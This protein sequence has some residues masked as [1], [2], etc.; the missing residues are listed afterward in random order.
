MIENRRFINREE[1]VFL[2]LFLTTLIYA[3]PSIFWH[4]LNIKY[5]LYYTYIFFIGLFS[6]YIFIPIYYSKVKLSLNLNWFKIF[7]YC[8]ITFTSCFIYFGSIEIIFKFLNFH[9]LNYSIF[10]YIDFLTI[11]IVEKTNI[12]LKSQFVFE[13]GLMLFIMLPFC[14]EIFFRSYLQENFKRYYN[15]HFALTVV[16]LVVSIRHLFLFTI[17]CLPLSINSIFLV[18]ASFVSFL[19]FGLIYEWEENILSSTI[20]HFLGN[21]SFSICSIFFGGYL[22]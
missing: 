17:L 4:K 10:K 6:F 9:P 21:L 2:T 18:L 5:F 20:V 19:F 16:A 3:L 11:T 14:E 22:V 15:E 12:N 1:G 7:N 13:V 8:A